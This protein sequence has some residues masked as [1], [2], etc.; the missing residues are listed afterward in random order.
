MTGPLKGVVT[1]QWTHL[2]YSDH[3][4]T[5]QSV[6]KHKAGSPGEGTQQCHNKSTLTEWN[7]MDHKNPKILNTALWL[8][9]QLFFLCIFGC[10]SNPCCASLAAFETILCW[11]LLPGVPIFS[12]R[13]PFLRLPFFYI[14]RLAGMYFL[15]FPLEFYLYNFIK[16]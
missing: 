4:K 3:N 7:M 13:L 5:L 16:L 11:S 9:F 14:Q 15:V 10:V 6:Q 2:G 8:P 1:R 12:M